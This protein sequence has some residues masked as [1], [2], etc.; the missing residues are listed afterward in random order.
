MM[1]NTP[2]LQ[3]YAEFD[4][5]GADFFSVPSFGLELVND[6]IVME[7]L[8]LTAEA[9]MPKEHWAKSLWLE[10]RNCAARWP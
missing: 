8:L 4:S 10:R 5:N 9:S 3:G 2:Y 7:S 6:G 1:A